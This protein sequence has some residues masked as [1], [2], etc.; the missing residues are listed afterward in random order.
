MDRRSC[1]GL[2]HEL[3]DD[4]QSRI[5]HGDSQRVGRRFIALTGLGLGLVENRR[6]VLNAR[7]NL[8]LQ[9]NRHSLTGLQRRDGPTGVLPLDRATAERR[10]VGDRRRHGVTNG[11]VLRRRIADVGHGD[12]KLQRIGREQVLAS[13]V[14]E[15]LGDFEDWLLHHQQRWPRQRHRCRELRGR[16][17]CGH[18]KLV[19][20]QGTAGYLRF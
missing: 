12:V 17:C 5:I 1:R 4:R 19:A 16:E 3:G 18:R 20:I 8:A 13:Q 10:Q 6:A 11:Q 2:R 15:R 9:R 14:F 7:R